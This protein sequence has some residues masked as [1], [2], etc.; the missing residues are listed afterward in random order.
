MFISCVC[1]YFIIGFVVFCAISVFME[2]DIDDVA[3]ATMV[4]SVLWPFA[5]LFYA[6][7]H[8]GG[9]L[10]IHINKQKEHVD[11]G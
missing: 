5:A 1:A 6:C 3:M 4:L 11:E 8:L 10:R 7:R 9:P 2:F